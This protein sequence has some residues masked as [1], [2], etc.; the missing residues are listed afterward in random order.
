MYNYIV[1][2]KKTCGNTCE[3]TLYGYGDKIWDDISIMDLIERDFFEANRE[4]DREGVVSSYFETKMPHEDR[5]SK[6]TYSVCYRKMPK[7][8]HTRRFLYLYEK[9]ADKTN[10][11][12]VDDKQKRCGEKVQEFCELMKSIARYGFYGLS[13][14]CLKEFSKNICYVF[15]NEKEGDCPVTKKISDKLDS[16]ND[17][18]YLLLAKDLMM[19]IAK[20]FNEKSEDL[21]YRGDGESKSDAVDVNPYFPEGTSSF[22]YTGSTGISVN[23][24]VDDTSSTTLTD[25]RVNTNT[26]TAD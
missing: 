7:I 20:E 16:M 21:E 5:V 19:R 10:E 1:E 18:E 13:K 12:K 4:D 6:R 11:Q 15:L 25:T 23:Y 22:I 14:E 2:W 8:E 17:E 3:V 24:N 26:L 9:E